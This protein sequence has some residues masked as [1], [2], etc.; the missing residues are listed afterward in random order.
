[1]VGVHENPAQPKSV[2]EQ[3]LTT[4]K[5][6]QNSIYQPR[7]S[8]PLDHRE[9]TERLPIWAERLLAFITLSLIFLL[10]GTFIL[11]W[12]IR[13]RTSELAQSEKRYRELFEGT[14]T[15]LWDVDLSEVFTALQRLRESGV[16][17]ILDYFAQNPGRL[18]GFRDL[19]KVVS[20][21]PTTLSLFAARSLRQL[22]KRLTAV[23]TPVSS[24]SFAKALRAI[25]Q[26]QAHFRDESEFRTLNGKTIRGLISFSSPRNLAEASHL[27]VSIL[28]ITHQRQTEKQ[29]NQVIEG[30]SLGFWDW[31]MQTGKHY[32]NDR[33]LSML[34]LNRSDI[35]N[36]VSDWSERINPDDREW[37]EPFILS[38]IKQGK[39][40][41]V[42]F[43][44]QHKDGHWV[45]IQGSGNV[46]EHDPDTHEPVRACGT[47]QDI[48]E[49]KRSEEALHTLVESMVGISGQNYFEKVTHELCRSFNA[50]G[51]HIG[52]LVAGN[53]IRALSLVMDGETIEG[54]EYNLTGTPC[55]TVM[56]KGPTHFPRNI[57]V[58]FPEDRELLKMD[59]QGYAGTPIFD[60]QNQVIGILWLVSHQP[61]M[62]P[63]GWEDVLEIIA[64]RT[65]AELE[66]MRSMQQLEHQATFDVLTDLPNR[67]LLLDRLKHAQALCSRHGHKGGLLFLDLDHFKTINDSLGHPVGDELLKEVA[68]RLQ[69][70]LRGE[71]V[72]ARLGGDE[73][74]VLFSELSDDPELAAQQAQQGAEKIQKALSRPYT[75][76]NNELQLTP[77]IGIVIFP[78]DEESAV[79]V[80][81]HA[82]TAMYRAKEAG[83][84][85]I[86]FFLPS[87][88]HLAEERLQLKKDLRIALENNQFSLAFQPQIDRAE[89]IVGAEALLRWPHP[90]QEFIQPET[91]IP[92]AEENGQILAIGEWVL[93][94]ALIQLRHWLLLGNANFKSLAVNVSPVQFHQADFTQRIEKILTETGADPHYLTLEITEGTLVENL[95]MA[96]RKIEH[97]SQLGVRFSIDDFGTGYASIAYLRHL[98]LDELKIDRS[99]VRDILTDLKDA[100]LV[101]TIITMAEHMGLDMVA[102]GVETQA[103][104]DFLRSKGCRTFQGYHFNQPMP[105]DAFEAYLKNPEPPI[106]SE[107]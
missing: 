56:H 15:S 60:E 7:L 74:V 19:V 25:A 99:F 98:P 43:R 63:S 22:Q 51:G 24:E 75:I 20:V 35:K 93:R 45:W 80:L 27:S 12:R 81:K 31:E 82:D 94:E 77:S 71:D 64:A 14:A 28:D 37:V 97:L 33:W 61:L 103:Q 53:N 58:L 3:Q 87:M 49:R 5:A 92:V 67:R 90:E 4:L 88:Q 85:C 65:S 48:S 102:E 66:R 1:M 47:H 13:H 23:M 16:D 6:D 38:H 83:R 32:V 46:V 10:V 89:R 21:N 26:G 100:N 34:G 8:T 54:Y 52:E 91:F 40:Y 104:F 44:L 106:G 9:K 73:F 101:E 95:E 30:A 72:P 18:A 29:L 55:E 105:A 79:D 86:R 69:S 70:E 76:Q 96:K 2:I 68:R 84:N 36:D 41:V 42:E 39:P 17:D 78:M 107:R 11:R 62:M 59:L 50:D 57:Q